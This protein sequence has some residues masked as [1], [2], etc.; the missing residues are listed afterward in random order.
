[1]DF[2]SALRVARQEHAESIV[3]RHRTDG[4]VRSCIRPK[5]WRGTP[6]ALTPST[7]DPLIMHEIPG[8]TGGQRAVTPTLTELFEEWEVLSAEELHRGSPAAGRRHQGQGGHVND[9]LNCPRCDTPAIP[10]SGRRFVYPGR[11]DPTWTE[12]DEATCPGCGRRLRA[13]LTGDDDN[14]EWM[15]AVC[16]DEEEEDDYDY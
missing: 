12:D 6:R 9:H 4:R 3:Y 10:A 13:N 16:V 11:E 2:L 5:S 7:D 14:G 8:S 1:M 15:E